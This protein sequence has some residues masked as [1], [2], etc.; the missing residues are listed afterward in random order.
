MY[1]FKFILI[2]TISLTKVIEIKAQNDTI[3]QFNKNQSKTSNIYTKVDVAP[4]LAEGEDAL[5]NFFIKNSKYQICTSNKQKCEKIYYQILVDTI[6]EI[7]K[8]QIIYGS[9]KKLNTE[10][11]RIINIMPPWIPGEKDGE[12]VNV[13]LTLEVMFKPRPHTK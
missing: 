4:K 9:N 2:F 6:G 10:L 1:F 11:K 13:L 5:L 12:K 7:K 3:I 8:F